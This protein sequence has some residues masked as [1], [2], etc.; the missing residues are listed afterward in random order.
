MKLNLGCSDRLLTGWINVDIVPPC[1]QVVDLAGPWPWA[2]SSVDEILA[3]DVIEHLPNKRKTMNELW[4]VLKPGGVARIQVP[5]AT[6]GD[7]GHCDPT[8]V[9]MWTQSD[10]EYYVSEIPERERFRSS[11]Y[12]GIKA[13]F[14]VANLTPK[15]HIPMVRHERRFGGHVMEIRVVLEA[16]K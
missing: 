13:D 5:H 9:S 3:E 16:L 10:F 4:R 7:G 2:D 12:Y 11:P 6:N 14:R 1:D 8:H 15:G